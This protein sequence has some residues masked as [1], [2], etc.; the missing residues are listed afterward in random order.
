MPKKKGRSTKKQNQ[1]SGRRRDGRKDSTT[2]TSTD[3]ANGDL[4]VGVDKLNLNEEDENFF[5]NLVLSNSKLSTNQ[6]AR[7]K[8]L[9]NLGNTC[10]LN[11]V[12]QVLGQTPFFYELLNQ[13]ADQFVNWQA[14]RRDYFK[15]LILHKSADQLDV[16]DYKLTCKLGAPSILNS[17]LVSL[18]RNLRS[19]LKSSSIVITP[20]NFVRE[21]TSTFAQFKNYDQQDSHEFLRCLL[22]AI[23]IN[24]ISRQRKSILESLGLDFRKVKQ[25][26]DDDDKLNEV[27]AYSD[28]SNFTVIDTL[29]GG[30]CISSLK[31][32]D[33]HFTSQIFEP[34]FDLSLPISEESDNYNN[35]HCNLNRK[36]QQP[37]FNTKE[38]K[39]SR[40]KVHNQAS[41]ANKENNEQLDAHVDNHVDN[42]LENVRNL[43]A[44]QRK[45]R[46][47]L[48][49]AARKENKKAKLNERDLKQDNSDANCAVGL[50]RTADARFDED[51]TKC[52][53]NQSLNVDTKYKFKKGRTEKSSTLD[54]EEEDESDGESSD[55]EASSNE[56][57]E[58]KNDLSEEY[59]TANAIVAKTSEPTN[60]SMAGRS[61]TVQSNNSI[62][63]GINSSNMTSEADISTS[64]IR[65]LAKTISPVH[66]ENTDCEPTT[67]GSISQL[68][69]KNEECNSEKESDTGFED[70]N[71]EADSE[72]SNST[73]INDQADDSDQDNGETTNNPSTSMLDNDNVFN[74]E[75]EEERKSVRSSSA[76]ENSDLFKR[77]IKWTL[78]TVSHRKEVS[79]SYSILAGQV[80]QN[81][82]ARQC[83]QGSMRELFFES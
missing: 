16:N 46:R 10:Y 77:K 82:T 60:S 67:N 73:N 26:K 13:R 52:D 81:R 11:S 58:L 45:L 27:K 51:K 18:L 63:S 36:Q 3:F 71:G 53:D 66:E 43:T 2:S 19:E 22:D 39:S 21:I 76:L 28:S 31:C 17:C 69:L 20:S 56:L 8:G 75:N 54:E 29:F 30:Y 64:K 57:S 12:I 23:R 32:Q 65:N 55:D 74:N 35:Y 48:K 40:S 41:S 70:R 59:S 79:I 4:L 38:K 44:K 72:E 47:Q 1:T 14:I 7:P 15:N 61:K 78:I 83:E 62:D 6:A 34:F 80:Y 33:C 49:K 25:V 24:E 9:T 50:N 5:R 42:Q 68:T 37:R